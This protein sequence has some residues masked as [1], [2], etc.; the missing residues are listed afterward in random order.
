LYTGFD[1]FVVY[2]SFTTSLKMVTKKWPQHD[3]VLQRLEC[4]N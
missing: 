3:G 4:N 2:P 1:V